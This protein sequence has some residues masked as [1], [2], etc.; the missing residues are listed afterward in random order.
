MNKIIFIALFS[1]MTIGINSQDTPLWMRYPSISP[2]G[3]TIVFTYKGDLYTVASSGGEARQITYHDAH[4]YAATWSK[5]GKSIAFASDRYGNFDIF[6][7]DAMGGPATRLTHHSAD[8]KPFSYSHDGSSILF[9]AVRQ[10]AVDHRQ[11]PTGAQ[12]ELYSVPVDGG[13]VSQV[14]TVPAEDAQISADGSTMLY[15]DRKGYENEWRKHHTSS[16]TRDLWSYNMQ[17][18]VH[19]MITDHNAEDRQPVFGDGSTVYFLSE[20]GGVFNVHFMSTDDPSQVT[21]L[22]NFETHPVR[23]LSRGGNTLCFGWDG[24]IYTMADRGQ[25]QKVNISIRTQDKNNNDKYI[26]INGGVR[27]MDISPDGKE[28]AFITRGEVFVTSV[29]QSFTKRITNTPEQERFVTWGPDGKSIVYSSE[30]DGTWSIFET[31]KLR[32]EEPFFY[33]S[34]LLEESAMMTGDTDHYQAIFSPDGKK[35][36]WTKGR[37]TLS[38]KNLEDNTTI[39]LLTPEDLYH[40]R[41]GDQYY[42][43]SPDS[44]WLL[45]DW[46]KTLSNNEVLLMA[47]DGSQRV[48]L[49]ESG[50]YDY[51]PKWVN[52]GK[53][54]LWFSN[55]NGL[56]SYATSGRSQSDVY[57]MF[58][59]Q[60]AWDKFNMSEEDFKLMKEIEEANKKDKKKEEDKDKEKKEEE[61]KEEEKD[62]EKKDEVK[63]L[64]FDWDHMKDRT[65]RLTIHSSSLGD[66]VLSKDGETLYYLA[67]FEQNLNLWSTNLRTK[68]TKMA[69]KL[70]ARSGGLTWDKDMKNLYLLSNGSI[71]KID[72]KG[73]K[74]TPVKIK[75]EMTY[76]AA[77]ENA[78]LFDHVKI[79]TGAIFYE[80]TFHGIDW[81]AM[82]G[83]YEKFV[84]HIGTPYEF[85]ELISELLGELNVSHAGARYNGNIPNGDATASLGV[86]M[87]YDHSANGI[88]IDEVMLGGPLDKASLDISAGDIIESI[89]GEVI[90]NDR[91]VAFYLN[92]KANDFTLIEVVDGETQE[93]RTYTVKPIS[94]GQENRLLYKRWV[95]TNRKEVEEKTNGTIGYVHIPGMS[96]G[97]YRSI[98][99]DMMGKYFEAKGVIV[100][101]RFNGGGDLVADLAMFFTGEPFITYATEDKV[102]GGEPTSRWTKPT[103]ALFNESM[104]S[105]GH[106]FACGYTDLNIGKTV[107][108]PVPG[109][110]SF[111]GWGGL[112]NGVRWGVVPVSAK[113]KQ[114]Q[115]MENNQT[116]PSIMVKNMPGIIDNGRD[117][118]LERAI[119]E[120]LIDT[121]N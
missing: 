40:F 55:R 82:S 76:D 33:A 46:G 89:D 47:A 120:M 36:A 81:E 100:D 102:V 70:N 12:P 44:K 39:D 95:D 4:D 79:R 17:T 2:D 42:T 64:T 98:Y 9:G 35:V 41:A 72:P 20:R 77:A 16:I 119:E 59:D 97:P 78:Y 92:R 121:G 99:Q 71:A 108:M 22:T 18:G 34:T 57:A 109:T 51:Y 11:Y 87:N 54:M 6:T 91:D 10:D 56:K 110:C 88:L 58:F 13:R 63:E 94:I 105:D 26:P 30:R 117:Q 107:G 5:D 114:G 23:F 3:S 53:Q 15:H 106:C 66:A 90:S 52:D 27:E 85:S 111:A 80:P 31:K 25:A 116:N 68:E 67:R 103:L 24:E 96:D 1:M 75:G 49:N 101:T 29:D 37:R 14:L 7:M 50:Y 69:M 84:P 93:R 115:W 104:Y 43:W 113:D 65:A 19:T 112:A 83:H 48:N 62:K 38:V 73:G 61:K 45:V 32:D 60:E 118:Q 21:Q 86:F 74:R 28:I 8:E